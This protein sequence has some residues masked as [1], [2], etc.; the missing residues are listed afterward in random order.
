MEEDGWSICPPKVDLNM[1]LSS[2]MTLSWLRR[3]KREKRKRERWRG[4]EI[5]RE[6][7]EEREREAEREEG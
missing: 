7:G 2:I 5:E 1:T 3:D 4:G 6:R